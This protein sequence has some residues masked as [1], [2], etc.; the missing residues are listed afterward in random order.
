MAEMAEG[1]KPAIICLSKNNCSQ[2]RKNK[3]ALTKILGKAM[4]PY[5]FSFL[6]LI[7]VIS[8]KTYATS[9]HCHQHNFH[10]YCLGVWLARSFNCGAH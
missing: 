6:I 1:Q 10:L 9:T 5:K 3:A 4:G 2:G 7:Q 8:N